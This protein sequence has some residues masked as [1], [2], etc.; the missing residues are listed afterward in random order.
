MFRYLF[1]S[2]TFTK[3]HLPQY[4]MHLLEQITLKLIILPIFNSLERSILKHSNPLK[5]NLNIFTFSFCKIN[6]ISS[7]SKSSILKIL[8]RIKT[9]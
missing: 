1:Y 9:N 5:I 7:H 2:H 8:S 6:N 4:S 3:Y